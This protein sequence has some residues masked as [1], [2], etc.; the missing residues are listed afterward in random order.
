MVNILCTYKLYQLVEFVLRHGEPV[1]L[2][3]IASQQSF[4]TSGAMTSVYVVSNLCLNL[5]DNDKL[6]KLHALSLQLS[7]IFQSSINPQSKG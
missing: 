1:N 4:I 5:E 7:S 2:D 3:R 6:Y